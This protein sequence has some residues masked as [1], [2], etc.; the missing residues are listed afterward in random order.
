MDVFFTLKR[1]TFLITPRFKL[2]FSPFSTLACSDLADFTLPLPL[3]PTFEHCFLKYTVARQKLVQVCL[4]I[5]SPSSRPTYGINNPLKC[6]FPI[7]IRIHNSIIETHFYIACLHQIGYF[8]P[9]KW[10]QTLSSILRPEWVT[11]V[12]LHRNDTPITGHSSKYDT[13]HRKS[14]FCLVYIEN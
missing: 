7:N 11:S 10:L 8:M 12:D 6:T 5:T 3:H 14:N 2:I 9:K 13:T 1:I 4:P